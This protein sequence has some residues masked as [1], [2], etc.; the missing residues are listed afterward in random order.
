M[1]S[2]EQATPVTNPRLLA[3]DVLTSVA[4]GGYSNL[5]LNSAINDAKL[6]DRD[7]GLA[8]TI[9][10]GVLQHQLLLDYWLKPFLKRADRVKPWV[11]VLLRTALFQMQYLDKVPKRA[12]FNETI[13]IAKLRGHEGIRRF[14][15]GVLHAIARDGIADPAAI[16]DPLTRTSITYSVP[17]PW[18]Q[19]LRKELGDE[20]AH[21]ILASINEPAVQS[22][23]VNAAFGQRDAVLEA[24]TTAGLT[25]VDSPVSAAGLRIT[26][27]HPASSQAFRD[28]AIT[29]QDES[30]MLPV[31]ALALMPDDQVLDACAAPG[32]K[33]TQI[34]EALTGTGHVTALDLYAHKVALIKA[35]ARRMHIGD[36]V[37]AVQLDANQAGDQ[38]A[39]ETFDK[40]LVDA[41]CSGLGLLR[42][43]P[44]I[45]YAKTL[46]DSAALQKIQ[47]GILDAVAPLVKKT[48]I[49]AYSTCTILKQENDDVAAAFIAAHPEFEPVMVQTTRNLKAD[50]TTP[51]LTIYPDDFGSDGF[52]VSAFRRREA[53]N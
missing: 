47:L 33:T 2:K 45:R 32:G 24:L 23:R 7:A 44:E 27:G 43:K 8:T 19:R 15:T 52:F 16:K 39:P 50:R 3:V 46:T 37:S 6:T 13:N 11:L 53:H 38:F 49:I 22:V 14:V 34:A 20:K 26:G 40:I 12:I 41:P 25:Y 30:A 29:I 1:P 10:Y 31:E 36:R 9:V 4:N 21:Q 28:G 17:M 48:G 42:R 5:A 51:W 18:V 35:N